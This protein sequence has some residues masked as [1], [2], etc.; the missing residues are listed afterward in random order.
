MINNFSTEALGGLNPKELV[1]V[2]EV[3]PFSTYSFSL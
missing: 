2:I 1:W 3:E